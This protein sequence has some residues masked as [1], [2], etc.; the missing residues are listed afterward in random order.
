M[1]I[2]CCND[3]CYS[4]QICPP[5]TPP[6][7]KNRDGIF[8]VIAEENPQFIGGEK[9]RLKYLKENIKYP[10]GTID[11]NIQKIVYMQFCI[12]TNGTISN[13]GIIRGV[14]SGYD[15]E[16]IRL[17]EGMSNNWIP[18][19]Q[20]GKPVNIPFMMPVK[21]PPDEIPEEIPINEKQEDYKKT[22][23]SKKLFRQRSK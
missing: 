16:A 20:R 18:A 21:F 13:I 22:Q 15:E 5:P 10:N 12:D 4:Q 2:F 17:V 6:L 8:Y 19:K 3:Y 1:F 9:A 23:K 11:S 7:T 14:G